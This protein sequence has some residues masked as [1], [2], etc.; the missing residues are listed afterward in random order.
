MSMILTTAGGNGGTVMGEDDY[1]AVKFKLHYWLDLEIQPVEVGT[2]W[3]HMLL[4][5]PVLDVVEVVEAETDSLG[6]EW[7]D[8]WMKCTEAVYFRKKI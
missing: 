6:L 8:I 2:V 4:Y 7:Q 5:R 1:F 3:L